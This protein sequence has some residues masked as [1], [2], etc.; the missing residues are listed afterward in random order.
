MINK[1]STQDRDFV[2]KLNSLI[3]WERA[4]NEDVGRSVEKIIN[5]VNVNGDA[6][7]LD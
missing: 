1:F 5:D 3:A 7:V 2:S 6:S 4:S